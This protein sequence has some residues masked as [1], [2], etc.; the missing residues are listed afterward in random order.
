MLLELRKL[1]SELYNVKERPLAFGQCGVKLVGLNYESIVEMAQWLRDSESTFRAMVRSF[2][3][4]RSGKASRRIVR[5]LHQ[6]F[7]P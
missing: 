6:H 3:P 7:N 1:V 4:Y 5:A 2:S